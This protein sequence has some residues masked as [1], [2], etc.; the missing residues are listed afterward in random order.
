MCKFKLIKC[1]GEYKKNKV[2]ECFGGLVRGIH[3]KKLQKYLNFDNKEYF[4]LIK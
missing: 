3:S 1:F 2:F 4:K